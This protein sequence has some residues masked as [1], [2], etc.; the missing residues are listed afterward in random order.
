MGGPWPVAAPRFAVV[1]PWS[2]RGRSGQRGARRG[3]CRVAPRLCRRGGPWSRRVGLI[4]G[5]GAAFLPRIVATTCA[6]GC[7][8]AFEGALWCSFGGGCLCLG[9]LPAGQSAPR[10]RGIAPSTAVVLPVGANGLD[11]RHRGCMGLRPGRWLPLPV[12]AV[13]GLTAPRVHDDAPWAVVAPALGVVTG[14]IGAEGVLCCSLGGGCL[15][16]WVLPAG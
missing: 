3:R 16:L 10:V 15:C 14:V 4:L 8:T 2:W 7:A 11:N 5:R 12:G 13:G 1:A 6:P 9:R